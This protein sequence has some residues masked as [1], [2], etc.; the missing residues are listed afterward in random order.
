VADRTADGKNTENN[1]TERNKNLPKN[2]H[3]GL[4]KYIKNIISKI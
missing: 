1:C 4:D 2:L 3:I